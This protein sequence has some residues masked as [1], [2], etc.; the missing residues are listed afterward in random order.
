MNQLAAATRI[1]PQECDV[2][3][4]EIPDAVALR[5]FLAAL[6][7]HAREGYTELR[8]RDPHSGA[9]RPGFGPSKDVETIAAHV[10]RLSTSADVFVGVLPR[11]SKSGKATAC[12][13]SKVLWVDCDS[14]VAVERA[15]GFDIPPSIVIESGSPGH[16]HC[17]WQLSDEV[18]VGDVAAANRRLAFHLGADMAATD[19]ARIMR[20]PGTLSFKRT[21][22]A[23]VRCVRL[24]VSIPHTAAALIGRLPDP[25]TAAAPRARSLRAAA[26]SSDEPLRMVE[27]HTYVQILSGRE[28][29]GN[30]KVR[31]PFPSHAGGEER[32][33]SFHCYG[34]GSFYCFG[35]NVGG[36][37]IDFAGALWS[38]GTRGAE[39]IEL[40]RRLIE[41]LLAG[42]VAS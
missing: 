41:D 12:L 37:I 11:G 6:H 21:P 39:F 36:S 10:E 31:C 33:P 18:P 42:S 17:Y 16:A 32:T 19:P 2:A 15:M 28:P 8:V 9:F 30:G 27:T 23:P 5:L 24:E 38:F 26:L 14:T 7:G 22:P 13:P 35:C 40:R 20:L 29:D 1:Q 3:P 25:P 4:R 34:D